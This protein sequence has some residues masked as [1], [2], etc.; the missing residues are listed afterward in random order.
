M[1]RTP[2]PFG[3]PVLTLLQRRALLAMRA[4]PAQHLDRTPDNAQ[5]L[6]QLKDKGLALFIHGEVGTPSGYTLTTK[7]TNLADRIGPKESTT[8]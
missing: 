4:A 6:R 5:T 8:A 3:D 2:L 1:N 7:G